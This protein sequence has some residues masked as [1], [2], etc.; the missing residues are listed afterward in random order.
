ME[1]GPRRKRYSVVVGA[2]A[3]IDEVETLALLVRARTQA[4][5]HLDD[6][7]QDHDDP[8]PDHTSVSATALHC[9][10]TCAVMSYSATLSAV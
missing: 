3:V 5:D 9:V 7:E 10:M 2:L 1:R 8:T 4:H 6:H